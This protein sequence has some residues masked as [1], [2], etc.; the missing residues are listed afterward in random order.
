MSDFGFLKTKYSV[1]DD[2]ENTF[3]ELSHRFLKIRF[4][5][6]PLQHYI[7]PRSEQKSYTPL[8]HKF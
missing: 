4:D 6:M 2:E 5:N 1:F 8:V 7:W 3:F